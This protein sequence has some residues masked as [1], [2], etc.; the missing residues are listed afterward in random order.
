[1]SQTADVAVPCPRCTY[2]NP[3]GAHHCGMC[4]YVPPRAADDTPQASVATQPGTAAFLRPSV[5]QIRR[6]ATATIRKNTERIPKPDN[7][8]FA[9]PST[10]RIAKGATT[11]DQPPVTDRIARTTPAG[12]QPALPDE[13]VAL[14][15]D[16]KLRN[17]KR[18]V[19][20]TGRLIRHGL[21]GVFALAAICVVRESL[22]SYSA[23]FSTFQGGDTAQVAA[24]CLVLGLPIGF[25]TAWHG[26]GAYRGLFVAGSLFTI[27]P[28][29]LGWLMGPGRFAAWSYKDLVAGLLAG[30]CVGLFIEIDR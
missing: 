13:I 9:Q 27:E 20:S 15:R 8:A 24:F 16:E 1:M 3:V 28:L 23:A 10:S 22:F 17:L 11:V 25:I 26:G 6:T 2:P 14:R 4:S 18:T 7:R 5:E 12:G 21:V 30:F 29:L 19:Y